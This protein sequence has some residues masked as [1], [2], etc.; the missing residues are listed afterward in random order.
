VGFHHSHLPN[1]SPSKINSTFRETL[2]LATRQGFDHFKKIILEVKMTHEK[3]QSSPDGKADLF[4]LFD[5]DSTPKVPA[6]KEGTPLPA[7]T[8][9]VETQPAGAPVLVETSPA[10][11]PAPTEALQPQRVALPEG[12]TEVDI[13]FLLE[14]LVEGP[15]L[16]ADTNLGIPT[17]HSNFGKEAEHCGFG[18]FVIKGNGYELNFDAGGAM[19]RTPSGHGWTRLHISGNYPFDIEAVKARL[20]EY[21]KEEAPAASPNEELEEPAEPTQERIPLEDQIKEF[22]RDLGQFTGTAQ[23]AKYPAVCPH[24]VLLTDG[25]SYLAEH[26]GENGGTAYW[27]IDAITSY[28]GEDPLKRH[29]FQFWKLII[30]PPDVPGPEQNTVMNLLTVGAMLESKE[31]KGKEKP[32]NGHRHASLICTNGNEKELVRQEIDFTD[33]LPVGEIAIYASVEEHPDISTR[34]KVMILLLPSEY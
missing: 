19:A 20:E 3:L 27:L 1:L 16:V 4:A 24:I 2:L 34:K 10:E 9:S 18:L 14:K 23:W 26:G 29:D 8:L 30:H 7:V 31:D 12:W 25:V 33:F 22:H 11:S 32:F 15:L 5:M 21:L 17:I 13:R 6:E 28:Q